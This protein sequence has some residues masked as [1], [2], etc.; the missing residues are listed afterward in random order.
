MHDVFLYPKPNA[1]GHDGYLIEYDARPSE[2]PS[3]L[4]T[5][6]RFVLRSKVKIED[7][8]NQYDVW[9]VW[10]SERLK[11]METV[12]EWQRARSGVI[13]PVWDPSAEWPWKNGS[14]ERPAIFDRRAVGMGS[15]VLVPKGDKRK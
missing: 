2:A 15:R 5:L 4:Q 1:K 3:L 8:S 7:V 13:E 11:N 9:S 6:K 10:G 14:D 12:R